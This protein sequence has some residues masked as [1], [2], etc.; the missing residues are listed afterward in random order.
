MKLFDPRGAASL[1]GSLPAGGTFQR[2]ANGAVR[3]GI[4]E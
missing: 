4:G 3:R 2:L 1:M